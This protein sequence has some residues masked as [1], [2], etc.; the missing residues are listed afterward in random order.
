MVRIN[1]MEIAKKFKE[2]N[3]RN[4]KKHKDF[5]TAAEY[6]VDLIK[7]VPEVVKIVLFGSVGQPLQKEYSRF[8]KYKH[9]GKEIYHECKNV[10]LAVWV[11]DFKCLKQIL[12]IRN[13]SSTKLFE[14]KHIGIAHHQIEIFIFEPESNQYIGRLCIFNECP[15]E[16]KRECLVPGCGEIPLVKKVEGFTLYDDAL[17]AERSILLYQMND[18]KSE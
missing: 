6:V 8:R 15:K 4:I 7:D 1:L 12:K 2:D 17:A 16:G 13:R 18:S 9:F 5:R 10:D 14:E 3:L 11:N